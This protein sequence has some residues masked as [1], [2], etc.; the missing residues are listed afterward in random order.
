MTR[1]Y[2]VAFPLTYD[3]ARDYFSD[4]RIESSFALTQIFTDINK[5]GIFN[6]PPLSG[7]AKYKVFKGK[8]SKNSVLQFLII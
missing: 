7:R 1:I 3:F 2:S 4:K 5:F 8:R 6:V